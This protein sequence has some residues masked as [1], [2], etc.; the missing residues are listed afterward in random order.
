MIRRGAT[1]T[2]T[3]EPIPTAAEQSYRE[4]GFARLVKK[5]VRG[6]P[7]TLR[8]HFRNTTVLETCKPR[9]TNA[10]S[11]STVRTRPYRCSQTLTGIGRQ[12]RNRD[13]R[14]MRRLS[15]FDFHAAN[16][17]NERFKTFVMSSTHLSHGSSI[18]AMLMRLKVRLSTSARI[19][20]APS[21]FLLET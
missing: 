7:R 15:R 5:A 4:I 20:A 17:L 1:P 10:H 19:Q 14:H 12:Y 6:G 8:G 13:S 2:S 9:T 3:F 11:P 18:G 16:Y 21:S